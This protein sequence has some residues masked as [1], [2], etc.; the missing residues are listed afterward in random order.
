MQYCKLAGYDVF[1][2]AIYDKVGFSQ[3]TIMAVPL[4]F[5]MIVPLT[6]VGSPTGDLSEVEK[7]N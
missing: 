5:H 1:P 7:L 2:S 3:L 6:F 4:I